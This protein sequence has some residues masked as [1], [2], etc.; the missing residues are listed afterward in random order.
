MSIEIW[1]LW[2]P[3]AAATGI[4]FA[5]GRLD[6]TEA[7]LVHAV[8]EHLTVEIRT[9]N[10]ERIA[11]A[12]DLPRTLQSP[13]CLLRREGVSI[14]REDIWPTD[15]ELGLPILLPGGEVGILRSWWH[16]DDR[17]EWRWQIELSNSIR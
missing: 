8:P 9:D 10:G 15:A 5:R 17:K 14:R 12:Q 13:V 16:A 2:Y 7:L 6:A 3:K 1:D 11:F 4:P